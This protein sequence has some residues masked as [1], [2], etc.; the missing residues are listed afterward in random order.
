MSDE[1]KTEDA[2][3]ETPVSDEVIAAWKGGH[4]ICKGPR[5]VNDAGEVVG[6][7]GCGAD[8]V[9]FQLAVPADGKDYLVKC[10]KCEHVSRFMTTPLGE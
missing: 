3:I 9:G 2:F 6:R 1:A 10:P 5:V 4:H 8:L 7:V